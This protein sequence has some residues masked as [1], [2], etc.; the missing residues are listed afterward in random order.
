MRM[1]NDLLKDKRALGLL[2]ALLAVLTFG[3]LKPKMEGSYCIILILSIFKLL[4]MIPL[5]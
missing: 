4:E 1:N 2:A 3:K 5:F